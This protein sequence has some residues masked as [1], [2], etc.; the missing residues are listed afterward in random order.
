MKKR[1]ERVYWSS[2]SD[3][4]AFDPATP[5]RRLPDAKF[6]AAFAS[7][8]EAAAALKLLAM[9]TQGRA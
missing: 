9:P 3:P 6:V 2:I 5:I 7:A 8:E 4:T 1:P